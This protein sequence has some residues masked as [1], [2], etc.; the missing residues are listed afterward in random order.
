MTAPP[1]LL[2][3]RR[4]LPPLSVTALAFPQGKK[5]G[6]RL[7]FLLDS[8]SLIVMALCDTK[9]RGVGESLSASTWPTAGTAVL[10]SLVRG[11]LAVLENSCYPVSNTDRKKIVV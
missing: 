9:V 2:S 1:I 3:P 6:E 5:F 7:K 8:L 11:Q 10:Q 4:I